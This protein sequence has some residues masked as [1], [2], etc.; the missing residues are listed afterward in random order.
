MKSYYWW[1]IWRKESAV[2][3]FL[4]NTQAREDWCSSQNFKFPP[5]HLLKYSF[6]TVK[7]F[8]PWLN[9]SQCFLLYLFS[10]TFQFLT[11]STCLTVCLTGSLWTDEAWWGREQKRKGKQW[12]GGFSALCPR[13][14]SLLSHAHVSSRWP[15]NLGRE[16]DQLTLPL[17]LRAQT[18]LNSS[19]K[20]LGTYRGQ[21]KGCQGNLCEMWFLW[22]MGF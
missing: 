10:T 16:P 22:Y 15:V 18:L 5:F 6:I 17:P 2:R 11:P 12:G 14:Q 20:D 19:R 21:L 8:L 3:P 13:G 1:F 4:S 7:Q 9:T